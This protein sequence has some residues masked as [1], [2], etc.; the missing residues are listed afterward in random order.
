MHLPQGTLCIYS[1]PMHSGF[2]CLGAVSTALRGSSGSGLHT[3]CVRVCPLHTFT[4]LKAP[5]APNLPAPDAPHTYVSKHTHTHSRAHVSAHIHTPSPQLR[6]EGGHGR[7]RGHGLHQVG[8]AGRR[9]PTGA[10]TA[11]AEPCVPGANSSRPR[12]FP[13]TR[14]PPPLPFGRE[15]PAPAPPR[16]S[17]EP[18]N[19]NRDR[20]GGRGGSSFFDFPRR[21]SSRTANSRVQVGGAPQF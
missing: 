16:V 15:A 9:G 6:P 1:K 17:P 13:P 8:G 4:R 5:P 12:G 21:N 2:G 10:V 20:R 18:R 7:T 19:V 11:D 3:L 14:R